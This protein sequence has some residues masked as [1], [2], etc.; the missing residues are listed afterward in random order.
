M[1]GRKIQ[2]GS[3]DESNDGVRIEENN[4][5]GRTFHDRPLDRF[6]LGPSILRPHSL[7]DV[8]RHDH[9]EAP[10]QFGFQGTLHRVET[11]E[12]AFRVG[13][14]FDDFDRAARIQ[15]T[16]VISQPFLDFSRV[17]SVARVKFELELSGYLFH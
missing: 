10:S 5:I 11:Q 17:S 7:S 14:G 12:P 8:K 1:L 6:R 15:D 3:I 16:L 2:R 13:A 9:Y 4:G